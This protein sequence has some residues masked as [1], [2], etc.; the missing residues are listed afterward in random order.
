MNAASTGKNNLLTNWSADH[1][2][3]NMGGG[4]SASKE[5]WQEILS[6]GIGIQILILAMALTGSLNPDLRPISLP[7]PTEMLTG[8]IIPLVDFLPEASAPAEST[9]ASQPVIGNATTETSIQETLPPPVE[10]L[11]ETTAVLEEILELS[12]FDSLHAG[13]IIEAVA[14]PAAETAPPA[15]A[16][17]TPSSPTPFLPATSTATNRSPAA[18]G[19]ASPSANNEG[20]S[21]TLFTQAGTGK[22]P[23]PPYPQ[24]ARSRGWQGQVMVR[25]EVGP[26][27]RPGTPSIESSSGYSLLDRTASDWVRKRWRWD[28]GQPR[29]FR[30]PIIFRLQ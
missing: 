27:G 6:W 30:I 25:V 8:E 15:T 18:T 19:T 22:F 4:L 23:L 2:L 11:P 12:S 17:S 14:P 21:T 24:E 26:D 9:A 13:A 28:A 10:S 1:V 20:T 7:E 5:P 29:N 3:W 16:N